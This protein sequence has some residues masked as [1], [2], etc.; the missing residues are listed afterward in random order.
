[1][2][3]TKFGN[4]INESQDEESP[5]GSEQANR[6]ERS[7]TINVNNVDEVRRAELTVIEEESRGGESPPTQIL[8]AEKI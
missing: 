3:Q 8:S 2:D 4:V 6:E 5:P 1:M 7:P